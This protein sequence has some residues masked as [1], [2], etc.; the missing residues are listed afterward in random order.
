[1]T[2]L[3]FLK[4]TFLVF[5]FGAGGVAFVADFVGEG[6]VGF[7][8]VDVLNCYGS[9]FVNCFAGEETLV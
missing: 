4:T 1:M 5:G 7:E 2:T 9:D 6:V 8:G 3:N